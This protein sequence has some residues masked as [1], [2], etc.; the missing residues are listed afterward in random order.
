MAKKRFGGAIYGG[1]NSSPWYQTLIK[2]GNTRRLINDDN[3][4]ILEGAGRANYET[5]LLYADLLTDA[6]VGAGLDIIASEITSRELVVEPILKTK[7]D[8][9]CA[10]FIKE[11]YTNMPFFA[12]DAAKNPNP[13]GNNNPLKEVAVQQ[14]QTNGLDGWTRFM[15]NGVFVGV[16]PSEWMVR[17]DGQY[18]VPERI[19]A[20]DIRRY[21]YDVDDEGII[22]PKLMRDFN[23]YEGDF[24]PPR[25]FVIFNYKFHPNE[26]PNGLGLG[27]R[28]FYP[29]AYKRE[30]A[31]LMLAGAAKFAIPT[32]KYTFPEDMSLED[33]DVLYDDVVEMRE[34][35]VFGA[36]TG[37]DL[38][39]L[40]AQMSGA[41]EYVQKVM[42][43]YRNQV[44][45]A[46][47]T[48]P[49]DKLFDNYK[50]LEPRIVK[51]SQ[52]ISKEIDAITN[53]TFVKWLVEYNFPD[54]KYPPKVYRRFTDNTELEEFI[55]NVLNLHAVGYTVDP[56]YIES[57]T[58]YPVKKQR[59]MGIVDAAE[60]VKELEQA[61][62]EGMIDIEKSTS[63]GGEDDVKENSGEA[64]ESTGDT[65]TESN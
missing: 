58:G 41:G 11:V 21:Q 57:V 56:E 26:N 22:Y 50:E 37:V 40:S 25:K 47:L 59:D 55:T 12:K 42:D 30:L 9:M 20:R 1:I 38:D 48:V 32:I 17:K 60:E 36:Q 49:F 24:L 33:R 43:M 51:R 28:C 35:S 29:V 54:V 31:T 23:N 52:A 15:V 18:I 61:Q 19:E 34:N 44:G 10:D 2:H 13:V 64:G 4:A 8:I 27:R 7:R 5:Y 63:E 3:L 65:A 14:Q 16:A 45:M 6:D 53:S 62:K 46:I 39:F